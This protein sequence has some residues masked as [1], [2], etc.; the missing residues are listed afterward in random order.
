MRSLENEYILCIFYKEAEY[1]GLFRKKPQEE[2][3]YQTSNMGFWIKVY[4][5]RIDF[6]SGVG[7]QSIPINQIASVQLAGI[8]VMKITLETTGG[9]TYSIPTNK[10]KEVQEAIYNTQT[11]L[12]GSSQ[13]QTGIA[14]EI[15][16]LNEL[17]EKGIITLEEFD[18]K[19][20]ELLSL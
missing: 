5:N 14:D 7:S 2:P 15:T 18:K 9:K 3:I 17:K 11:R 6:K 13:H 4:P 12:A 19:K 10:K 20:K 1:M 8:G 16:K